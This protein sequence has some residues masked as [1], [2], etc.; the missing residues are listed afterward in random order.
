MLPARPEGDNRSRKARHRERVHR[1]EGEPNPHNEHTE[2]FNES[3][4]VRDWSGWGLQ[5]IANF[6]CES[7][8]ILNRVAGADGYRRNT[9]LRQ[10]VTLIE[11]V[12]SQTL[13]R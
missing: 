5:C 13:E 2:G 1:L 3:D 4:R 10:D 12:Q 9:R 8:N 6:L 11:C 7:L